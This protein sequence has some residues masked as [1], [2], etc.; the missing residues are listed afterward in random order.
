MIG[1]VTLRDG[2]GIDDILAF[3]AG[4]TAVLTFLSVWVVRPLRRTMQAV[5]IFIDEW[6]GVEERPGHD[7]IPGVPVRLQ[8]I[9]SELKRN[10]GQSLKDRVF[11]IDR[12]I[13][14]LAQSKVAE[15]REI[16]EQIEQIK[17]VCHERKCR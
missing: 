2:L 13:D 4:A 6:R 1:A 11:E 17:T 5:D 10:G 9:E 8:Q 12:K 7:A 3:I 15:H 16:R 14:L